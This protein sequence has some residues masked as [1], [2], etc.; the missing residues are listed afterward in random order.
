MPQP[1][2]YIETT[3]IGFLASRPSRDLITRAKQQITHTWWARKRDSFD[4]FCSALV[5]REVSA[6]DPEAAAERLRKLKGVPVLDLNEE[7]QVLAQQLVG[8]GMI[9]T[10]YFEDALHVAVA[11]VNG[12]AYL[13]TWNLTH[14]ANATLRSTYEEVIRANGYAPPLICTPEELSHESL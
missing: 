6:G 1:R 11:T 3:I 13:M 14:I 12:M 8:P 10:Q 7:A 5:V 4:L 2:V 9:P